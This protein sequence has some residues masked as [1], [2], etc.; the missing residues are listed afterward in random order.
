LQNDKSTPPDLGDT[1]LLAFAPD[2]PPRAPAPTGAL[3]D[4]LTPTPDRPSPVPTVAQPPSVPS[5]PVPSVPEPRIPHPAPRSPAV[6][7]PQSAQSA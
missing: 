7:V 1:S 5:V 3:T 6:S 2:L 4:L